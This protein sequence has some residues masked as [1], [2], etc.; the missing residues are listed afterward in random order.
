[1]T[2]ETSVHHLH[3]LGKHSA[4][5]R[6]WQS[7]KG[8]VCPNG[9]QPPFVVATGRGHR[10]KGSL[11]WRKEEMNGGSG[12]FRTAYRAYTVRAS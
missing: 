12:R 6:P 4:L 2:G 8:G 3:E 9:A 5:V 11:N 10:S 7:G 1:M